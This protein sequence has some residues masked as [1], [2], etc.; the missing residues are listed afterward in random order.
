MSLN[1]I[2]EKNLANADLIDVKFRDVEVAGTLIANNFDISGN[3]ELN[4]LTVKQNINVEGNS[5]VVGNSSVTENFNVEGNGNIDGNFV[6]KGGLYGTGN[7]YVQGT[8]QIDELTAGDSLVSSITANNMLITTSASIQPKLTV[9]G[10]IESKGGVVGGSKI[11]TDTQGLALGRNLYPAEF[12]NGACGWFRQF[13]VDQSAIYYMPLKANLDAYLGITDD[14]TLCSFSFRVILGM[15]PNSNNARIIANFN[16]S[17]IS[18][19]WPECV[20]FN[21][22]TNTSQMQEYN[23]VAGNVKKTIDMIVCRKSLNGAPTVFGY[24]AYFHEYSSVP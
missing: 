23:L 8:T 17:I 10:S 5:Y 19:T 11:A 16:D 12:V 2:M 6:V 24:V 7:L 18:P 14:T 13:Y 21:E 22:N 15:V 3:V 4:N 9:Q 20:I 1:H